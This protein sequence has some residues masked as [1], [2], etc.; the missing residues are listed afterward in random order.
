MKLRSYKDYLDR[1][2]FK[3]NKA[4]L[5]SSYELVGDIAIIE[6]DD[7]I[8]SYKTQ[9]AD[10][11]MKFNKNIKTVLKKNG[12]HSGEF[13]TQDME[14]IGGVDKR[15]TEYLENGIRLVVNPE[16][17]YFSARLSTERSYLMNLLEDRKRILVLFSGVGPYTFNVLKKRPNTLRIDS[18]EI[19]P[20][21]HQCALKSLE[22]N[23][24]ILKKSNLYEDFENF[25]K[26]N[27]IPI[28]YKSLV[29]K[30]NYLRVNFLNGDVRDLIYKFKLK[31]EDDLSSVENITW[32]NDI[33][34]LDCQEIF[35]L[36]GTL[37]EIFLNFDI[38]F[39]YKFFLYFLIIFAEEID[40]KIKINDEVY[41]FS[42]K[43][44]K[45]YLLNLVESKLEKL[46]SS[47]DIENVFKYDEIYMPLPKDASLFLEEAFLV[48]D[49]GAIVHMYDFLHE[50]DF[51]HKSEE[52]IYKVA[53]RTNREVKILKTRKVGQYSPRKFR[54]CVD[55]QVL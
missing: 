16:K 47:F 31:K 39:N 41:L 42:N 37:E 43:L 2:L 11:L 5:P 21:G 23:K 26:E 25:V 10:A 50:N 45:S 52:E 14:F 15:E 1:D 12:I 40:F 9:I 35:N 18:I 49:R 22:L 3:K 33:F 46:E 24:N 53:K 51:P 54:V 17:V 20:I 27:K 34:D 36:L 38:E 48:T 32:N 7:K 28:K 6:I 8:L 44:D 55:F 19:N 30:I 13:R 29:E 4:Y